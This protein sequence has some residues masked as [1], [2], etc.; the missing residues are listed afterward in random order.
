MILRKPAG[1][2][3][4]EKA[5]DAEISPQKRFA[6]FLETRCAWC[7]RGVSFVGRFGS[8]A[9]ASWLTQVLRS[10]GVDLSGSSHS[11]LGSG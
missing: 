1:M 7:T 5:L 9:H 11:Q 10:N 8:D 2:V 4:A 6:R 3:E